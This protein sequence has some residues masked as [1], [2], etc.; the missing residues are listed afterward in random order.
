MQDLDLF[1]SFMAQNERD[2]HGYRDMIVYMYVK[3]ATNIRLINIGFRQTLKN[4]TIN[5]FYESQFLDYI[6]GL[7][8]QKISKTK[9][10]A[11]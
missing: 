11:C 9:N 8:F 3:N 7:L 2:D 10:P 5:A 1:K 4:T 6:E